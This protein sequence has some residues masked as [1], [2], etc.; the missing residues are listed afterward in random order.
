MSTLVGK[1]LKRDKLAKFA[2]G[3]IDNL[4]NPKF[5]KIE[6]VVKDLFKKENQGP[7]SLIG[8][9]SPIVM[10]AFFIVPDRD[11]TFTAA[12]GPIFLIYQ[13]NL[14]MKTALFYLHSKFTY[15][16]ISF[17]KAHR[18]TIVYFYLNK[19]LYILF[20]LLSHYFPSHQ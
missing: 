18:H 6:F 17:L 15:F 10:G 5:F 12:L 3:N 11:K 2:L 20:S 19:N 16:K 1:F 14:S 8:E 4:N 9:F 7:D 13:G